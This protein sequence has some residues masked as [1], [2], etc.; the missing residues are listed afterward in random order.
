MWHNDNGIQHQMW[1]SENG[2]EQL[3]VSFMRIF[4]FNGTKARLVELP[5]L[6]TG[7]QIKTDL[8]I[9]L[10]NVNPMNCPSPAY[11]CSPFFSDK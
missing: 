8:G 1:H 11:L 9:M 2:T 4:F 6:Q 5:F 10:V 3:G 7:Q